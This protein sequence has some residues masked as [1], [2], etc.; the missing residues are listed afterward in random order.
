MRRKTNSSAALPDETRLSTCI[1][2]TREEVRAAQRLR[3]RV[4]AEEMHARLATSEAGLDADAFDPH[5]DHLLVRDDRTREV[6]GTYRIL[7]GDRARR[8]GGFYSESEFDLG[9]IGALPGLVE[10]GRACVHPAY[11]NGTVIRLLWAGLTR[12]VLGHRYEFV[13][14]CASMHVE[15]ARTVCAVHRELARDHLS[16]SVWRVRPRVPFPL[17]APPTEGVVTL[18]A[19]IKGYVRL[20][21]YVCGEPGWDA[22]FGT[23]DFFMMLPLARLKRRYAMRF[24]RAA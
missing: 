13:V 4:F 12:Y 22:D 10:I 2:E 18:P 1:A 9:A 11:R 20:G 6:V 3:H 7:P 14:G 16:P 5:C 8:L 19:L 21:A 24:A 23:A 15:D 17:D